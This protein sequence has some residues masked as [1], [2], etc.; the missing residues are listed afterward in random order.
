MKTLLIRRR[1]H[2]AIRRFSNLVGTAGL[3]LAAILGPQPV[4]AADF[5]DRTP[6][7]GELIDALSARP[8]GIRTRGLKIVA[9]NDSMGGAAP[10]A[11]P[12]SA[13]SA[14]AGA[15]R[16]SMSIQFALNSDQVLKPSASS[17][18]N[19]AMALN[20][21]GL[22][23]QQFEVIGHTDITGS[24]SYNQRLSERRARSVAQFLAHLGVEETRARTA[25]KGPSQLLENVPASAPQQRRVEIRIVQ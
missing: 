14:Q 3:A 10:N 25:G 7:V 8:D 9:S 21:E 2:L 24:A 1:P 12:A 20:S 4:I 23:G 16:V 15:G 17:L 13:A 11:G 6:S 5:G 19:L 22:K 18:S